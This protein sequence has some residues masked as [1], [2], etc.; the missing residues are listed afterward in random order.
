MRVKRHYFFIAIGLLIIGLGTYLGVASKSEPIPKQTRSA[1]QVIKSGLAEQKSIPLMVSANG[2]VTAINTVDVRPQVQNVVRAI[3]V[4]EGQDVRPGQKLFTLDERNDFANVDKAKAQLARDRADLADAEAT[5]KR[6]QELLAKNFISQAVVDT[7]RNKVA[8]LN[9][10]VQ[11]DA[12][13][14]QSSSVALSYN[15]ISA[16]IGGRIGAISVHPGSLAQPTG[17]P[18][19]TISQLDPIAVSFAVPEREL[20]HITASYPNGNAPVVVQLPNNKE[21]NGKLV[22]I[23]NTVDSQSGTIRMKAQFANPDRLLWPGAFV[24]V[25]LIS[26]TLPDAVVIPAQAIVTGPED[27]FVYVVQP[28][29]SVKVQKIGVAAIENG[30][31]AVSGLPAGVRVVVEGAQNLR[32]NSKVKEMQAAPAT[33][34]QEKK[35]H[36]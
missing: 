31:A 9:G 8:S 22:F 11:A 3:H 33:G 10:T 14:I 36:S 2:Y 1:V 34:K 12:A 32:S 29:G 16:S 24:N 5:L 7:A 15:Q 35:G 6:N 19:V 17:T 27:K 25:R 4:T 20:A 28:D 23:D 21:L 26:R 18:M 30:Q 13:A